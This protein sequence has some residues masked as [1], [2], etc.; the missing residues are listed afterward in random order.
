MEKTV[1]TNKISEDIW[2][3]LEW[4]IADVKALGVRLVGED[5]PPTYTRRKPRHVPGPGKPWTAWLQ[6]LNRE[7]ITS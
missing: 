1:T 5:L 3:K 4:T 7:V 2:A 6:S